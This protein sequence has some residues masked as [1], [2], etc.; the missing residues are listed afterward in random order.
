MQAP[1]RIGIIIPTYNRPHLLTDC[2]NPIAALTVPPACEMTLILVDNSPEQSAKSFH[3]DHRDSFPFPFHYA[4]QPK[5]GLSRARNLGIEKALEE[6]ADALLFVDDDMRLL[7]DYLH[8]LIEVMKAKNADAVRGKMRIIEEGG[9][10]HRTRQSSLFGETLGRDMLAGNGVLIKACLFKELN[11]RFDER[12]I[13]GMEDGDFFYRAHLQGAKLYSVEDA[14]F[15]EYRPQSRIPSR[16][17]KEELTGLMS[18]RCA[19]T[20]VRRY[21]GGLWRACRYVLRRGI[22]LILQIILRLLILPTAPKKCWR[23][24]ENYAYRLAGTFQGL[25]R[26]NIPLEPPTKLDKK[27]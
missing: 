26:F 11:L 5:K 27:E 16:N 24:V 21:R 14:E 6:G 25:H 20:A 10:V 18:S 9:T 8:K 22:P 12:F 23:K 3:E 7:P 15:T 19:H 2:A 1:T 13:G 17:R 4:H